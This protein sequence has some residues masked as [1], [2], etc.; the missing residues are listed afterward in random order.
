MKNKI[1]QKT[2]NLKSAIVFI[3]MIL[4]LV[5]ANIYEYR[6]YIQNYNNKIL[7]MVNNIKEKYPE[8]SD[9]EIINLLK[10]ENQ[11]EDIFRQ[12]GF[13]IEKESFIQENEEDF[14]KFMII[15]IAIVVILSTIIFAIY[16]KY[17]QKKNKDIEE[18]TK[19]ID[20]I[21]H[22]N[23]ELDISENSEDE[24]SA[25]KNEI[26]KT[27][28]MLREETDNS[29]KD[30]IKLKKSLEDISHQLK[31][32]LTSILINL[33]NLMDN[34]DLNQ[35]KKDEFL[36]EI[37]RKTY[38]IKFL[39]DALLKLSKFDVNTIKFNEKEVFI[40][41]L[42]DSSI[43]NVLAL[44]DLKNVKIN[45]EGDE[46]SKITCDLKWQ[47]EAVTNILKNA[48][49]HSKENSEVKI[50][51]ETNNVYSKISIKNYGDEISEKDLK[52]IFERF[53][54]GENSSDDSIGIG[55][56][57][58]KAIIEKDN[59]RIEIKVNSG[60]TV[61]LIKYFIGQFNKIK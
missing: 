24:L 7:F 34:P 19:L 50:C 13:N 44:A 16:L 55:L 58:S 52:H 53:Y 10:N 43:D 2:L 28:L 42:I 9:D 61:F 59:G 17:N 18:I 39:I 6:A 27:T 41:E 15:E 14:K 48:I 49:E 26:Y 5:V 47:V 32:P 4:L 8:I 35:E 1:N 51:Y 21:N 29:L 12:Y 30:K 36:R 23:Y 31:T 56:A 60:E 3:T 45:I 38:N 25:L 37:K 40:K 11:K 54:K 33:E 22:R 57:L 46:Q 20:K